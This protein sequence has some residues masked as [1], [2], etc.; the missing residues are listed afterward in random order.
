MTG[1]LENVVV[2]DHTTAFW[3]SLGV[4]LLADFGAQVIRL[5]APQA[6]AG[7][8]V[9]WDHDNE[10]VNRNKLSLAVDLG[11]PR[12]R[13]IIERLV[14]Q[15]DVFVTDAP[16]AQLEARRLDYTTL[17]ALKPDLVYA[18][19]TG[20]GPNGPDC[21]LPALDELAA[22][23]T[24]MMPIL[25]QP[26]QP[27]VYTGAGQMY[28]TVML[29]YGV[30]AALLHRDATGEG[31]EVDVSLF[32]GNMYGASLDLQAFLAI[33]GE[34]FLHPVSRLDAGNPMS[35]TLYPT[36][37]GLWVTL[38]MPDTD[39]W[40]PALAEVTGLDVADERFDSHERRCEEHRLELIALLEQAF[41]QQ[42]A[43]HW[44]DVFNERQMSADVIEDY[45]YPAHD[46]QAVRNRY[47]LELDHQTAGPVKT[48]GSPIFM[49]ETPAA[50]DRR[51]PRPGEHSD[52]VLRTR[53][54]YAQEEVAALRAAGVVS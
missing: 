33:G 49:S 9:G 15:A 48:L 40:W 5:D 4:A 45:A 2:L 25:P 47:I 1:A 31:Q 14:A 50:L 13:Q 38:T 28:T 26:G 29:A 36:A 19:A 22:A 20:F 46:V 17:A 6:V 43:A 41:Q 7:G 53:L 18:H 24:G 35:G 54:G 12:G 8:G 27:P 11:A 32:G 34:R 51:A 23:R 52:E 3:S 39:R 21:D 16:F 10:L 37:D 42:P 30:M 44:R